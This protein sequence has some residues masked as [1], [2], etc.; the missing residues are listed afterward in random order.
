A[1][2]LA[3]FAR[4]AII[5]VAA[6]MALQRIGVGDNIVLVAFVAIIGMVAIA[7]AIAFG[8]GGRDLAKRR[9]EEWDQKLRGKP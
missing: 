2:S 1:L 5:V 6:A 7:A 4:I 8:I 9:L 3:L